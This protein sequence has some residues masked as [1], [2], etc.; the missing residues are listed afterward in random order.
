MLHVCIGVF[1]GPERRT[2][3]RTPQRINEP[4]KLNARFHVRVI[5]K[6]Y[7]C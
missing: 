7:I 3:E 5:R 6:K 4:N 2:A 1:Q